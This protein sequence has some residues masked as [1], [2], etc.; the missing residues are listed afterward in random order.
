MEGFQPAGIYV[1]AM[2]LYTLPCILLWAAWQRETR[3]M[4]GELRTPWRV[5]CLKSGFIGAASATALSLVFL[6]SY[7]RNGG[8]IH[9]SHTTPGLW[10]MLGPISVAVQFLSLMLA[11]IGK[12]K[13][14]LFL[15][16]WIVAVFAAEYIVFQVAFD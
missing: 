1:L 16:G 11:T 4:I 13:V 6:F 8:G 15:I 9:G 3:T 10:T 7:L 12:T 14:K 2:S 5:S